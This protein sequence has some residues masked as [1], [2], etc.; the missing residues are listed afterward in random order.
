MKTPEAASSP[1]EAVCGGGEGLFTR[2]PFIELLALTSMERQLEGGGGG[3]GGGLFVSVC[4]FC[5]AGRSFRL[6]DV[7]VFMFRLS[8]SRFDNRIKPKCRG[9]GKDKKTSI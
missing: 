5:P 4:L 8:K 7:L 6:L 1:P 2:K 3:G 9:E